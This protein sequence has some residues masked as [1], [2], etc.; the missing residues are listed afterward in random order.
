[1][2]T[3]LKELQYYNERKEGYEESTKNDKEREAREADEEAKRASNEKAEK[4]H[5]EMIANRREDL[6]T[7]LPDEATGR[8][9]K[10]IALRFTDGRSGQRRFSEDQSIKEVFNWVDAMFEMEREKVVLTTMN[11]K[12]TLTWDDAEKT[13]LEA[14][15]GKNTGFRVSEQEKEESAAEESDEMIEA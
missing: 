5:Q 15:L 13:L 7:S 6:K 4:E 12:L 14:E 8:E 11:G 3:E 10:K 1:M 9:A 2:Q